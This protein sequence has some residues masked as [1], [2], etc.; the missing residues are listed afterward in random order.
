VQHYGQSEIA[1]TSSIYEG[2][3]LPAAEAMACQIPVIATTGGS[4]PE[5]VKHG[6]T[7]ILVPPANASALANAI[8]RLIDDEPLR[9]ILGKAGRKRVEQNFTW[10]RTAEGVVY[11]YQEAIAKAKR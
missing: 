10:Q 4:L 8:E 5:V 1:I 6:Y 11:V 9:K 3:G 7:G 2:F